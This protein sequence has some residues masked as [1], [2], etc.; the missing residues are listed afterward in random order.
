MTNTCPPTGGNSNPEGSG[1][2][3]KFQTGGHLR[4][5]IFIIEIYLVFG[6]SDLEFS[7]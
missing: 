2:K 1:Q 5:V 4:F 3:S 6:I 7:I